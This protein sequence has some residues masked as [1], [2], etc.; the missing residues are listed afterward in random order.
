MSYLLVINA[1]GRVERSV[2]RAFAS[3]AIDAW[4]QRRPG[5]SV[6]E[7]DLT[8]NP[9]PV[10]NPSW[11][12]AAF[13]QETERTPEMGRAL[14]VSEGYIEAISGAAGVVIA[15]PMYNFGVPA[16]LKGFLD[17]I[18]RVGRTFEFT[19]TQESPYRGLLRAVPTLIIV[20]AG[21]AELL[22]GGQLQSMDCLTPQIVH[23]LEFVG[24]SDR[25]FAYIGNEQH[26]DHRFEK[27][28]LDAQAI[29][30]Q[31][32]QRCWAA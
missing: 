29:I 19:G 2:S 7:I 3:R 26:K 11:I 15:T 13:A 8:M 14:A 20:S 23:V 24:L 27:A 16:Q 12:A 18:V 5:A 10:V 31:F 6:R 17:Q 21:E 22:P 1:S 4:Q 30:G 9:P 32:M 28:Q 25:T